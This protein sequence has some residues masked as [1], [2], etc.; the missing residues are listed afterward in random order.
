MQWKN[1]CYNLTWRLNKSSRAIAP[2]EN[3][4]PTLIL[5]LT[6]KQTLTGR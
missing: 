6:L 3:G 2:K 4:T 1:F 5:T